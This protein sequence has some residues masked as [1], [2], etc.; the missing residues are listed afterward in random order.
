MHFKGRGMKSLLTALMTLGLLIATTTARAT[1]LLFD[2][3]DA[4]GTVQS[5]YTEV[6]GS[7]RYDQ[8][9]GYGWD[10]DLLSGSTTFVGSNPKANLLEDR[11]NASTDRTFSA[12]IDNGSYFVTLYFWHNSDPIT[13]EVIYA[14]GSSTP[15]YSFT[16]LN[17]QEVLISPLLT[18]DVTDTRLDLTFSDS[19]SSDRKWII[20]GIDITPVPIPAALP[21]FGSALAALG[22]IGWR[23]RGR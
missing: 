20:S 19:D 6:R 23:R 11:N 8:G 5:G 17:A 2:M 10:G 22:L 12:D 13:N 18:V 1:T 4:F 3:Q 16:Q 14:E 7:Y 15:L 9:R 21:L